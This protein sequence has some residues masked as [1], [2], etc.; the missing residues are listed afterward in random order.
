MKMSK[1]EDMKKKRRKK[2][3]KVINF[4]TLRS[5]TLNNK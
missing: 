1:A 4:K 3:R 5:L 2:E